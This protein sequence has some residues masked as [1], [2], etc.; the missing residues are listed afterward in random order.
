M[1]INNISITKVLLILSLAFVISCSKDDDASPKDQ[2]ADRLTAK[3]W[4]VSSWTEN[5][6]ELIPG[7]ITS[8]EMEYEDWDG[9]E[10][11]FKWT[12]IGNG[13]T[14]IEKGEFELNEVA[15]EIELKF[16]SGGNF[17]GTV[18]M[19]IE[20]DGNDLILEG[21]LNGFKYEIDAD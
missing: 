13:N 7:I 14:V 16:Q 6:A 12:Y 8:F 5:G 3:D 15:D 4:D 21:T 17:S 10:G 19:D 18:E 9:S 2:M 11:E 1:I 20:F